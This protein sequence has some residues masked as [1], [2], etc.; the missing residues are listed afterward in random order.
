MRLLKRGEGIDTLLGWDHEA[1]LLRWINHHLARVCLPLLACVYCTCSHFAY[2]R[3]SITNWGILSD[4]DW[5]ARCRTK[6]GQNCV[7]APLIRRPCVHVALQC[8][9]SRRSSVLRYSLA[10]YPHKR[11]KLYQYQLAHTRNHRE[12]MR[13]ASRTSVRTFRTA[14][15]WCTC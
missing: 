4:A 2:A 9:D 11:V 8:C 6:R 5:N 1:L 10:G 12:G 13:R 14:R 3:T 7:L 15:R